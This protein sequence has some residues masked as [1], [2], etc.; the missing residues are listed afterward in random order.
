MYFICCFTDCGTADRGEADSAPKA[1]RHIWCCG[2]KIQFY[3][4]EYTNQAYVTDEGRYFEYDGYVQLPQ[5]Q[6]NILREAMPPDFIGAE[7]MT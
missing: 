1:E 4:P 2:G 6:D 7:R 3:K 5:E